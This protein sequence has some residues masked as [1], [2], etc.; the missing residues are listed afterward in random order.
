MVWGTRAH[1]GTGGIG[2]AIDLSRWA[3]SA[4]FSTGGSSSTGWST[5]R[6]P[7]S[8]H[9]GL[10]SIYRPTRRGVRVLCFKDRYATPAN[11][12]H[13]NTFPNRRTYKP[14]IGMPTEDCLTPS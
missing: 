10:E 9:S 7:E 5:A 13:T 2:C 11:R 3:W 8:E 4:G 6:L 1:A 14:S 12:V